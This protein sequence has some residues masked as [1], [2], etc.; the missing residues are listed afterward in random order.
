MVRLRR[1]WRPLSRE[2]RAP[3]LPELL[4]F[5]CSIAPPPPPQVSL[6]DLHETYLAQYKI[7][8]MEGNA[9]GEWPPL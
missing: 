2:R 8:F 4:Y 5:P 1:W 7:A 3:R 6:H 9:T